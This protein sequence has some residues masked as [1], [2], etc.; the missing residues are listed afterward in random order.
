MFNQIDP[1]ALPPHCL[2]SVLPSPRWACCRRGTHSSRGTEQSW[3]RRE[4]ILRSHLYQTGDGLVER[5]GEKEERWGSLLEL[6]IGG[7]VPE[8]VVCL[9]RVGFIVFNPLFASLFDL[10]LEKCTRHSKQKSFTFSS[11]S[12]I[13][14]RKSRMAE[15][16]TGLRT[17]WRFSFEKIWV[18]W[19]T[20]WDWGRSSRW[21]TRRKW[22][23]LNE[24]WPCPLSTLGDAGRHN[25]ES[26][27]EANLTLVRCNRYNFG[28]MHDAW[29]D[30][31]NLTLDRCN[32]GFHIFN[33]ARPA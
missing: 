30:P 27:P 33:E 11:R 16:K 12:G 23:M 20:N 5:R 25:E 32:D 9:R 21:Q 28:E 2:W 17:L 18:S 29:K 6:H 4:K 10:F 1:P 15:V 3:S 7:V 26:P 19:G 8:L 31:I 14:L 24:D 13:P 22:W